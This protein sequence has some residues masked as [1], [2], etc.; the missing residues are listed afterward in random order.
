MP[1]AYSQ[2]QT[3]RELLLSG[4]TPEPLTKRLSIARQLTKGVYY[5]HLYDFVHK[6]IIPEA[7]LTLDQEKEACDGTVVFLVGFQLI[8]IA[9]AQTN[10]QKSDGKETIYQHPSRIG[11]TAVK[12]IM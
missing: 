8:H 2:V 4:Y 9:D 12:F 7:I 10:T 1:D 11:S 3:R 5:T 6:N